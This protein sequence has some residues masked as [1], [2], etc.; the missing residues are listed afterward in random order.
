MARGWAARVCPSRAARLWLLLGCGLLCSW[1]LGFRR[2]HALHF[3]REHFT[4]ELTSDGGRFWLG[5][6]ARGSD[7]WAPAFVWGSQDW[8]YLFGVGGSSYREFAGLGYASAPGLAQWQWHIVK[9]HGWAML[10]IVVLLPAARFAVRRLWT[11]TA[12]RRHRLGLCVTCGYDLRGSTESGRCPECGQ[13][14]VTPSE[15]PTPPRRWL[16][17]ARWSLLSGCTASI[18]ALSDLW[19]RERRIDLPQTATTLHLA[20]AVLAVAM[21][22]LAMDC[23]PWRD[24]GREPAILKPN[25]RA[26]I[27]IVLGA[28]NILWACGFVMPRHNY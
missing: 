3:A 4:V 8:D 18:V 5:Y 22:V 2:P 11:R 21:G 27:G 6:L 19:L 7:P 9:M 17:A 10:A 20:L 24:L 28:C 25:R 16:P 23:G 1:L 12:R 15:A 14:T 13:T 26:L